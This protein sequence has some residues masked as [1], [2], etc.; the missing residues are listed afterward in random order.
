MV[1]CC[2][3]RQKGRNEGGEEEADGAGL[4]A[5]GAM[6]KVVRSLLIGEVC[7]PPGSMGPR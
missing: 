3:E 6:V 7:L 1:Y 2:G 5:T 4:F